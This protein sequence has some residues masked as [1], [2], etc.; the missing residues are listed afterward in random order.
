MCYNKRKVVILRREN[1]APITEKDMKAKKLIPALALALGITTL[2]G[3][4]AGD[5]KLAF[6]PYWNQASLV[7]QDVDETLEYEATFEEASGASS[8]G[9]A[10][11]YDTGTYTTQLKSTTVD[12]K[13]A[14]EYTTSFEIKVHYEFG[15]KEKEFIDKTQSK[16]VFLSTES[17]LRPIESHVEIINHSPN[18]KAGSTIES[19]YS[20][21]KAKWDITY[22]TDGNGVCKITNLANNKSTSHDFER[23][24]D[25]TF[26]DKEQLVVALRA[27]STSVTSG[28]MQIYSPFHYDVQTLNFSFGDATSQQFTY[29]LNGETIKK[30]VNYRAATVTIDANNPGPSQTIWIASSAESQNNANR[31]VMLRMENPYSYNM[32][33][34][35]YTLKAIT[36]VD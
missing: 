33:K 18:N 7:Y 11:S 29:T 25:L 31:N 17:A 13:S 32:G 6:Q 21:L 9:Y 4:S 1:P 34:M 28:K 35:V 15:G 5:Q 8:L 22:D 12:G 20:E 36:R 10:F 16:V 14:Y 2:A 30:T 3:C 26:V 19:C 27:L 23:D 24:E